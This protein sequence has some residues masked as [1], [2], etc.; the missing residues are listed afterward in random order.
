MKL[1]GPSLVPP[2]VKK[3]VVFLHGLGANGDDLISLADEF[4]PD[5]P[6]TAFYSPNA[7]FPCDMAPYGYQW[8]SLQQRVEEI[9]LAGIKTAAPILNTYLD[10]LLKEH[11]LKPK[12]LALVG[13]SQG[14]MMSLYVAPRRPERIAGV[15]GYAGALIA[16][17]LLQKEVASKPPICLIHGDA[18]MVV[19]YE[20]MSSA[21]VALEYN[22]IPCESH[23]RPYLGHGIDGEGIDIARKFLKRRLYS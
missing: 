2:T 23:T 5:L 21:E 11:N 8:F 1:S 15:V 3:I 13:F 10:D 17:E 4:A 14:T 6:D 16:P 12:D 19:P 20:A 18:D 22:Q 9:M 7:P